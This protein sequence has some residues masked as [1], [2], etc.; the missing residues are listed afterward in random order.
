MVFRARHCGRGFTSAAHCYVFFLRCVCVCAHSASGT[1]DKPHA[2]KST[3][4]IQGQQPLVTLDSCAIASFNQGIS[5][6]P[7]PV[8]SPSLDPGNPKGGS[9]DTH[10]RGR[11]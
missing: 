8:G 2:G 4:S 7:N 3:V 11:L 5:S 9:L 6:S 1:S 10:R